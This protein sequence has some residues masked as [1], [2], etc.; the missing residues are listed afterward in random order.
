MSISF[1]N[2][3]LNILTPGIYAEFNNARAVQGTPARPF[4]ALLIGQVPTAGTGTVAV[5]TPT[6]IPSG[7]AAEGYFAVGSQIAEMCKAYKVA[8][9]YTELWA[10]ALGDDI[11]GVVAEGTIT[12][13]GPATADGTVYIYIGGV[14][15]RVAVEDGDADSVICTAA[16]AAITAAT[17]LPV[18]GAVNGVI[19]AQLDISCKWLGESGNDIPL[20]IN[21]QQGD[22]YPTG[23]SAVVV[24]MAAG[25]NSPD[26]ADAVTVM[27]G[28]QWNIVG[29]GVVDATNVGLIEDELETRWGPMHQTEGQAFT[30]A[31]GTQ[32]DLTSLGNARNSLTS[33]IMG[34]G[35]SPT[36]PWIWAASLAGVNAFHSQNDP[37]RP[38]KTL[39]VPGVVAPAIANI[40]TRVERNVLLSDG[41]ATFTVDA[42]GKCRVERIVTTYQTNPLGVTDTSYM[43]IST[44]Q[45][46][47]YLRYSKNTR[48]A[49]RFPRHKLAD[50]GTNFSPGQAI[51]TPSM[52]KAEI[53]SL[54]RE[55]ESDGLVENFEQFKAD[56]LVE[57]NDSDA[58]RVDDLAV[59]D[60]INQFQT[61]AS[62]IQFLV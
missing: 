55:W 11:A 5:E 9:P 48:I 58:T 31:H 29:L 15:V 39:E 14:Q 34:A 35:S 17:S 1:D 42:T 6:L 46:L 53:L 54:F 52:I 41:I 44:P 49:L 61:M 23:V 60:L 59:P 43:D 62:L 10:I 28:E 50:D 38:Q 47:A 18:D 4:K 37:A 40:F 12:F 21:F 20:A 25:A 22:A 57:R 51:A 16:A 33:T 26:Y 13:S 19:P 24:Q 8:D 56:L 2:I 45:T 36:P 32:G 27:A 3:P 7:P 30:A